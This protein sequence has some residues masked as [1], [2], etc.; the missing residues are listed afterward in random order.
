VRRHIRAALEAG[1]TAEEILDTLKGVSVL[2]IQ[3]VAVSLP[4]LFEEASQSDV[5]PT[6]RTPGNVATPL[7]DKMKLRGC[8]I[9]P[10]TS[11][12]PLI[13]N[14]SRNSSPWVPTCTAGCC[15][16]NCSN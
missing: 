8:S 15:R 9:R 4:I 6:S 16:P 7:V 10:G 14:G 2:G 12:M 13:R 3:A 5:Q 11:S 1:A